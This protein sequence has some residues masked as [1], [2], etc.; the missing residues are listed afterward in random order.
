MQVHFQLESL[1]QAAPQA[2]ISQVEIKHC[3]SIVMRAPSAQRQDLAQPLLA[4]PVVT[5][6]QLDLRPSLEFVPLV[7]MLALRQLFVPTAVLEC[8]NLWHLKTCA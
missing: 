8:F 2:N 1:A 5:A 7:L 6:H 4:P 3:V